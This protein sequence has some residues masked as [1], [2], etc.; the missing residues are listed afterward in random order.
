MQIHVLNLVKFTFEAHLN[1][2]SSGWIPTTPQKMST[3]SHPDLNGHYFEWLDS[4][5]TNRHGVA[6]R[7]S[8]TVSGCDQFFVC[9]T[10]ARFGTLN[11]LMTD[12]PDLVLISVVTPI[13]K[14]D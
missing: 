12:V 5:T 3:N 8:A 2:T 13:G 10:H 1:L 14:S 9:P 7:D 6:A 11:L 4:T